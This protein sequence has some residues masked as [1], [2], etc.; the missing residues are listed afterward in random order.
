MEN[1]GRFRDS[2]SVLHRYSPI[3]TKA[4]KIM[5]K[6]VA[7]AHIN[8]ELNMEL[9]S[10]RRGMKYAVTPRPKILVAISA[11]HMMTRRRKFRDE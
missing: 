11:P 5:I 7:K 9:C 3:I 2:S 8:N 1:R 6:L 10:S 4:A